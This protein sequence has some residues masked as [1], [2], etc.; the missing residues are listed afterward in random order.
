M[1]KRRFGYVTALLA[2][3]ALAVGCTT[4]MGA[5]QPNTQ[6]VY[7]NSNVKILGPT[8]ASVTKQGFVGTN[9]IPTGDDVRQAYDE[10][11][12]KRQGA[13]VL[14]NFS[15]NTDF[16]T[17]FIWSTATY[18]IEGQAAQMEVGQQRLR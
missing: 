1:E 9:V 16:T 13:N 17:Y 4:S 3:G 7:P 8:S 12:S 15:E 11:L 6:F 18:T 14:V 2:S 10:A 5:Q